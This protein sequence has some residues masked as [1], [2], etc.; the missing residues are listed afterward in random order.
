MCCLEIETGSLC[1]FVDHGLDQ[2]LLF[3]SVTSVLIA[4]QVTQD[5]LKLLL[6][7]L[8]LIFKNFIQYSE[9]IDGWEN[10]FH[11]LVKNRLDL[12]DVKRANLE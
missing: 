3:Q 11:I 9:S 2:S 8:I 12:I 4:F 1:H 10:V 7:E 5:K 6:S